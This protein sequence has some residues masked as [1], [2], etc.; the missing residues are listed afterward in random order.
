MQ[1]GEVLSQQHHKI[2]GRVLDRD[3]NPVSTVWVRVYRE[4]EEIGT[5]TTGADGRYEIEF[6][7]GSRI[8]LIRYDHLL[9]DTFERRHPTIVSHLSGGSDH[10]IN[11]IM[12]DRVGSPSQQLDV[13]E[14][15]FAYEYLYLIDTAT[16]LQGIRREL[17]DRY[18]EN[19]AMMKPMDPI[20]VQRWQQ[21]VALYMKGLEEVDGTQV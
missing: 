17:H 4:G 1:Q 5:A 8:T 15:V 16:N 9:T 21:V 18:R 11:K 7:S 19:V 2:A 3:D 6:N 13:P 10:T 20:T 14:T 12:P